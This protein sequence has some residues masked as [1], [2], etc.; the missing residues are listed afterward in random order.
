MSGRRKKLH[1][2]NISFFRILLTTANDN[3]LSFSS[4]FANA[5]AQGE[6]VFGDAHLTG[7]LNGQRKIRDCKCII[8]GL[9]ELSKPITKM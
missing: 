2:L 4:E 5:T 1:F 9:I 6:N 8:I 7:E 3:K